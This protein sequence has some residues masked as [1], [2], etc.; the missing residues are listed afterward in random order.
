MMIPISLCLQLGKRGHQGGLGKIEMGFNCILC[1]CIYMSI[2]TYMIYT[3]VFPYLYTKPYDS[4]RAERCVRNTNPVLQMRKLKP[5]E[6]G[7]LY[8]HS[9]H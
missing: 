9:H 1:A 3:C 8:T 4:F 2:F 7:W 6:E 5:R